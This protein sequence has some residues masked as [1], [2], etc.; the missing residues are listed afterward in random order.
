MP[1]RDR[2][3][4]RV[5][6]GWSST[7]KR[8]FVGQRA[9]L[10]EDRVRDRE[11]ADVVQ[12]PRPAQLAPCLGVQPHL[13]GDRDGDLGDALGVVVGVR[14]LGVDH[15]RERLGDPVEELLVGGQHLVAWLTRRDVLARQPGP[16][17]RGRPRRPRAR[18]RATGRTS[19]RSARAPSR[20]PRRGRGRRRTPR[21]SGRGTRSVRAAGSLRRAAHPDTRVRSSARRATDRRAVSS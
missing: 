3:S 12:Q 21:P 20:A 1:R 8:S 9:A 5:C 11:L 18:R 15:A 13:L 4:P 7:A 16:E 14:R 2:G 6:R 19:G 17:R 10:V